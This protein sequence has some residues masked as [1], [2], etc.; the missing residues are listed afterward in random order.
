MFPLLCSTATVL[1][2]AAPATAAP[3]AI[4]PPTLSPAQS[5]TDLLDP[6]PDAL[7]LLRANDAEPADAPAQV[8]RDRYH[9]HHHHGFFAPFFTYNYYPYR[10]YWTWSNPYWNGYRW[11][12]HRIREC[13]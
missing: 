13:D 1:A 9:H 5:Y 4:A 12:R 10:C 2:S 3:A 6:I 11:V 8:E 7:T